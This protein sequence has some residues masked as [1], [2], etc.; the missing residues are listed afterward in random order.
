MPPHE[1][2][3]LTSRKQMSCTDGHRSILEY[4]HRLNHA[5]PSVKLFG[6]RVSADGERLAES[7]SYK[8]PDRFEKLDT[9]TIRLH[10]A[11]LMRELTPSTDTAF[12]FLITV[13]ALDT[14]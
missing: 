4:T 6:H 9:E 2:N 1:N 8:L 13:H 14:W 7:I 10:S 3:M 12:G 5:P 11:R